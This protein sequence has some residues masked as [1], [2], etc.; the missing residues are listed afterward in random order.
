M[1]EQDDRR[2]GE[3]QTRPGRRSCSRCC[4]SG[5]LVCALLAAVVRAGA[6]G[7]STRRERR[8]AA[9][10]QVARRGGAG[11][12][13]RG[14]RANSRNFATR[15]AARAGAGRARAQATSPAPAGALGQGWAGVEQ[16]SKCCRRIST[17][18]TRHCPQRGFGKLGVAEAAIAENKPVAWRSCAMAAARAWR[19]PRRRCDGPMRVG[20]AYVR[21][22]LRSRDRAASRAATCA[23]DSYLALRQGSYSVRRAR[24]QGAR[25]R[26]RSAGDAGAG[27]RAAHRRRRCRT[28]AAAPFGLGA[29]PCFDRRAGAGL[30]ALLAWRAGR[31]PAAAVAPRPRPQPTPKRR[32]SRRRWQQPARRR[33]VAAARPHGTRAPPSRSDAARC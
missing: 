20:V 4:R 25:Q 19:S 11:G 27:Q 33:A 2:T 16:A 32:R 21:L 5:A 26:R 13:Q 17:R 29:L 3:A 22:P 18:P 24:R 30:L 9:L 28:S 6:A 12:R 14:R 31:K 1:T 15:L 10:Q 23:D 7:S 8:E